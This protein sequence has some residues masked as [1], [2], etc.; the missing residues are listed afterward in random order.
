MK[1][2]GDIYKCRKNKVV[3]MTVTAHFP[4][5]KDSILKKH[6]QV[7]NQYQ[8]SNSNSTLSKI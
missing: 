6:T 8:K 4:K 2:Q 1:C 5:F 7:T 3:V